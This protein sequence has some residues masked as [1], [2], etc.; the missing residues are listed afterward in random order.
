MYL[1]VGMNLLENRE[2]DKPYNISLKM[3]YNSF[4]IEK[5]HK[6]E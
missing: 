3:Y 6:S 1:K 2:G 5:I 4:K